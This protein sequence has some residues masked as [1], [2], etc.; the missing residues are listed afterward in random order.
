MSKI[1]KELYFLHYNLKLFKNKKTTKQQQRQQQ[2]PVQ[3]NPGI[4]NSSSESE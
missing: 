3:L 1:L 2:K 4:K